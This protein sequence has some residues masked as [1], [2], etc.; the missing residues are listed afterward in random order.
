MRQLSIFVIA[1]GS[2]LWAA[3]AN[4]LAQL[5]Q[6]GFDTWARKTLVLPPQNG[7]ARS[8]AWQ[9]VSV[10][11]GKTVAQGTLPSAMSWAPANESVQPVALPADLPAGT[12]K[13]MQGSD[14]LS[15]DFVVR[16][17]AI[18][19][20]LKGAIRSFYYQRTAI[21]LES[22]Y[23]GQWARAA[24]HP[25]NNVK[26]HSST[27]K[28]GNLSS[29]KGWY[30]AG[31]YNKYI[32][33]SGITC[34]LLLHLAETRPEFVDTLSLNIPESGN[35]VPDLLDEIRWNLDWML[36][37]QDPSDGGVYHKLTSLDF[38]DF[39]MPDADKTDRYVVMKSSPATLD[40]AMVMAMA[41]RVYA[42][43]DAT[44]AAKCLAAAKSAWDWG[45]KNK[46]AYYKQPSDVKTG[47]YGDNNDA[48]ERFAAAVELALAT[49]DLS[50]FSSYQ[51]QIGS[52]WGV[53]GWGSVGMLG[54]YTLAANPEVFG[55]SAATAKKVITDT[56]DA[57]VNV[58]KNSGWAVPMRNNDFVWGSNSV[59][60]HNGL[61]LALA[62][63]ATGDTNYLAAADDMLGYL[64]GR[65]PL[66][67][68]WVTGFGTKYPMKPHHRPSGA[69]NIAEPVPG[70]LIGGPHSGGQDVGQYSCKNNYV[71]NGAPAKSWIDDEC[72]YA[73]NE[74]A[75]NWSAAFVAL[76]GQL[77]AAH[78]QQELE[79]LG[80]APLARPAIRVAR[81]IDRGNALVVDAGDP[82]R[83][84]LVDATGSVLWSASL[85]SRA[86]STRIAVPSSK[87]LSWAVLEAGNGRQILSRPA[88]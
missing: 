72:S 42:K 88:L 20:V 79:D 86:T 52:K 80:A 45:N 78:L 19:H 36:T 33:N 71:V 69:D 5:D 34:W 16:K 4:P 10:A 35:S 44:F 11:D 77:A 3:D 30:D 38:T 17:R 87:V 24:G 70:F 48:D 25:D 31:D 12:Y 61:H 65:N 54:V 6:T 51:S 15:A 59:G 39:I 40:F 56:A 82:I 21:A 66:R 84:R 53:P 50:Y 55:T 57:L 60:A 83:L 13:L 67:I 1:L 37:M 73:T 23:A 58:W 27:G 14:R 9:L 64:M 28:S 81:W 62:W 26:Y 74:I 49:K 46:G 32:V 7:G 85:P 2:R 29:S 76:A 47:E 22:K 75:I 63:R 41:S 68:S 43:S 8:G 18:E